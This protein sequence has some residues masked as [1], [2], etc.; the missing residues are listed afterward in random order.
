MRVA[1][2]VR[3]PG[4]KS[5]SHR[6][7]LLA[8][9]GDGR[10]RVTRILDS[11]DVRSTAG[12]LRAMGVAVPALGP[13]VVVEGRGVRGLTAP[14]SDLDCGNSGTTTRLTA[15]IVAAQPF[16]ARFVGDASLSRR[17]M[18]RVA[19]PLEAMGAR[20]TYDGDAG[21]L[22]MT[23]HGGALQDLDWTSE[24]SSAQVKSA[25]VLA[26]VAAG[27]EV[28]VREPHRSRDHTERMLAARGVDVWVHDRAV[29]VPAG[30]RVAALD[31]A[32]PGDPSSAAFFAALGALASEGELR[33]PDVCLNPTRTGFFFAL[34]RMGARLTVDDE[35]QEGGEDVGTVV[36]EGGRALRGTT[37]EGEEV[38]SMIDELPLLACV[39]ACAEGETIV[40]GASELRVKESDRITAVVTALRAVGAEAEELPDG[41]VV[42]GRGP[43][44]FAGNVVTHADHRL[45]MAFGVLGA[46]PGSDVAVDDPACVDVSFPGFWRALAGAIA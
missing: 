16:A 27:V 33:L 19:R 5:I 25:I 13:D 18:A 23:V 11:A 24:T 44:A 45:A 32:V 7:L 15:G 6:A 40:R 2:S 21:R 38:P 9:L 30:A 42:Y 39:A 31:T 22:P 28:T 26:G 43:R 41:F 3:V 1:G 17:P 20:V 35:R 4:D 37:V 8:A 12:V 34:A 46:L 29:H 14:S 36:V 10:S